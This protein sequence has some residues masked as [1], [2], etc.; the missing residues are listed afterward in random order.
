MDKMETEFKDVDF[1]IAY[2]ETGSYVLKSSV[3]IQRLDDNTVMTQAM[4]FSPF[5]KAHGGRLE[6]WGVKL[7]AM[8]EILEQWL[9]CQINWMYLEPI[10]SSPDIMK[11]LPAEAAKFKACDRQWQKCLKIDYNDPSAL[12]FTD[13]PDLLALFTG[14]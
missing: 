11:Q 9:K 10:F 14:R 6:A 4:S 1:E 13:T 7:N 2:R 8:S 3:D 12:R 5:K